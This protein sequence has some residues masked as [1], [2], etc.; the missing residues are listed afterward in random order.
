MYAV[1]VIEIGSQRIEREIIGLTESRA[2]KVAAGININLNHEK[3]YVVV[4]RQEIVTP[5][6]V[7]GERG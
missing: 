3:F 4:D 6:K 7:R 5:E 1:K 2:E